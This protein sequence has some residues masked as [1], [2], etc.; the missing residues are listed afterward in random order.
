MEGV[1][2]V[3][4]LG[5]AR[6]HFDFLTFYNYFESKCCQIVFEI[7]CCYLISLNVTKYY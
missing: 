5:L 1:S 6:F 7:N 3:E 4:S 2:G